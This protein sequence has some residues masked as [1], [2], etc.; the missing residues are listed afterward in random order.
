MRLIAS[1]ILALAAALSQAT[2]AQEPPSRVGRL[3]FTQGSVAL[4]QDP[5]E[6]WEKAYVNSPVTSENSIWTDPSARAEMRVSGMAIRLDESTQL[7]VVRLDEDELE[8]FVGQGSIAVRVRH[9]ANADRLDFATPH[10]RF[11]L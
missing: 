6:G 3:A 9:F 1:F 8:A 2:L 7:D 5:D 11:R 4:Y 10:A